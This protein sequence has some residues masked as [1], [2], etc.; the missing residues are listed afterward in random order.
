[1]SFTPRTVGELVSEV[2]FQL[3]NTRTTDSGMA[4]NIK[5]ALHRIVNKLLV[6]HDH[7]AFI[8][9]DT[10]VT[11][12]GQGE[13]ELPADLMRFLVHSVKYTSDYIVKP[14]Y[15]PQTEWDRK[16]M[17]YYATSRDR[18]CFFTV[19]RK[20]DGCWLLHFLPT[21][22]ASYELEFS[23]VAR[24][25]AIRGAADSSELDDRF[26]EEMVQVLYYGAI[27]DFP[28]YLTT[29]QLATFR[30]EFEDAKEDF[31]KSA[32]IAG[33]RYT[34]EQYGGGSQGGGFYDYPGV[35]PVNPHHP[36]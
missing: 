13:Y 15:V 28:N 35:I 2:N 34:R 11:S 22:T 36:F 8:V 3:C 24:P 4:V 1:M 12:S 27:L 25:V 23:Y 14:V 20:E 29:N 33:Q 32:P 6:K 16:N 5:E 21:P 9:R 30:A 19:R 31:A 18:P 26:P 17:D 7:P 10:L